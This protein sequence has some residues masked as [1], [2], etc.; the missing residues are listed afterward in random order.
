M[1]GRANCGKGSSAYR[2][3]HYKHLFEV[4]ANRWNEEHFVKFAFYS[5]HSK[6]GHEAVSS[7]TIF[8]VP[9]EN[10]IDYSLKENSDFGD[11][12]NTTAK[13]DAYTCY[14]IGKEDSFSG[15][16]SVGKCSPNYVKSSGN[17]SPA[18]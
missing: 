1:M 17:Y 8:V 12:C 16:V 5:S 13:F 4:A 18:L 6:R 2:K 11:V 15:C 9:R 3:F 14:R 10:D 7:S